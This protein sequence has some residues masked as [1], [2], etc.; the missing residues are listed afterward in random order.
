MRRPVELRHSLRLINHGPTTLISTAAA[1]R[2]NV[3]AAAWVMPMQFDPPRIAA[4]IAS[5][6]ETRMLLDLSRDLVINLPTVEQAGLVNAAGRQSGQITDKLTDHSIATEPASLVS[7]PLISGCAGWLECRAATEPEVE[8]RF[9]LFV[10]DVV[11]AWA[12][13]DCFRGGRWSFDD[14]RK[15]TIHHVAGGQ[16]FA[17]GAPVSVTWPPKVP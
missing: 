15:R 5:G 9:D 13:S 14:D 10:L 16:F 6:C 12:D 3:M 8:R 11:A 7:A 17:T 2:S 4:V 1:G